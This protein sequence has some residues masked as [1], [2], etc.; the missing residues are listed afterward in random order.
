MSA[1]NN[2]MQLEQQLVELVKAAVAGNTP[3]VHVLTA[4]DLADVKEQLQRT[5]A[6]HV[7]H[8]GFKVLDSRSDGRMARLEHTWLLVAVV[9]TAHR[10]ESGATARVE[11]GALLAQ[12]L[13]AVMGRQLAGCN[14]PLL[15]AASPRAWSGAG[16]H[17]IPV[18]VTAETFFSAV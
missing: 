16:F 1:A 12:T 18:A 11:A 7:I 13:Q 10:I 3:A 17:Y 9:G 5:P 4:A 15:P 6:V 8:G 14:G 2:F